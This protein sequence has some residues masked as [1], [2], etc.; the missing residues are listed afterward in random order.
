MICGLTKHRV[1]S[2]QT[3]NTQD[4]ALLL[5]SDQ[6]GN[7]RAGEAERR[8]KHSGPLVLLAPHEGESSRKY[9]RRDNDAHHQVQKSFIELAE[10]VDTGKIL[11]ITHP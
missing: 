11:S 5:R 6:P 4:A 1:V 7:Q 8:A 10:N 9:S 2:S 3:I